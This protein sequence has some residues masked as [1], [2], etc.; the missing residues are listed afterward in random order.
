ARAQA[1]YTYTGNPFSY[2]GTDPYYGPEP[3]NI[4]GYFT[5]ASLLAPDTTYDLSE[6]SFSPAPLMGN[7]GG[8][9]T[10][11]SF[12]DGRYVANLA[13]AEASNTLGGGSSGANDPIFQVTTGSNGDIVSWYIN[14]ISP[15]AYISTYNG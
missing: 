12:T 7:Q 13:T 9:L 8:T 2:I 15:N 14:V 4:S 3:V 5:V 11:F 10:D 1:T 6:G